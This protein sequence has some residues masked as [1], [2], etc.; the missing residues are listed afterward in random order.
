MTTPSP[1]LARIFETAAAAVQ[2]RAFELLPSLLADAKRALAGER[3]P[4][5]YERHETPDDEAY[6]R[7]VDARGYKDEEMRDA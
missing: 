4:P 1:D 3:V 5:R 6:K 2:L 7:R